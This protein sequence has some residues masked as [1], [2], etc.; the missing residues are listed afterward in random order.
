ML[1]GQVGLIG[2]LSI[3]DGVKIGAQSG[4]LADVKDKGKVLLGSPA[5]GFTDYQRSYVYF[6]KLPALKAEIDALRKEVNEL[7]ER[8]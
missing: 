3:A 8:K 1:G 6:R 4:L 2:H 7:K 5:F